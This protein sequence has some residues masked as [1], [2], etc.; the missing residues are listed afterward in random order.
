MTAIDVATEATYANTIG[1]SR[2]RG[3]S[4]VPGWV[5]APLCAFGGRHAVG[6]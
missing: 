3:E 5:A 2:S 6:S 1:A 4:G